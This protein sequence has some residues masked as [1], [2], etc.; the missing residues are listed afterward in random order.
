MSKY[1]VIRSFYEGNTLHE[2]GQDFNH[3]DKAYVEK[4]LADGN[5]AEVG[6][7]GGSESSTPLVPTPEQTTELPPQAP[8]APQV[9]PESLSSQ[10]QPQVTQ[11]QAQPLDPLNDP[12]IA[13]DL[14]G[15]NPSST[16]P[17]NVQIN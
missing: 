9:Q 11:P 15:T 13:E 12:T 16:P 3:E 7:E 14:A 2:E 8:P 10:E 5:I 4:C 17:N 1:Q 6:S